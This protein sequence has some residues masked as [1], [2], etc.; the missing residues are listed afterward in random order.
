MRDTK[1]ASTSY[2]PLVQRRLGVAAANPH[3]LTTTTE[4]EIEKGDRMSDAPNA[5]ENPEE[6]EE[7]L[8]EEQQKRAAARAQ[9]YPDKE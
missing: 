1:D 7:E 2:E 6:V 3:V 9:H 8:D 5:N 4:S